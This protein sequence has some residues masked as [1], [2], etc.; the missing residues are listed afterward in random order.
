VRHAVRVH[1]RPQDVDRRRAAETARLECRLVELTGGEPLLQ[2]DAIP[3]MERLLAPATKSCS[4]PAAT[5]PIDDVPDAVRAIVDVK[6][7][8]S[9]EPQAC[10]GPISIRLRR[11]TR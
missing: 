1:G 9:G 2:K 10:T 3:L 7:P 8:A 11:T 5:S 6:C 4:K